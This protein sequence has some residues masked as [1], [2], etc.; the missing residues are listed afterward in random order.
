MTRRILERVYTPVPPEIVNTGEIGVL[1][2]AHFEQRYQHA[3]HYLGWTRDLA[4]RLGQHARGR[5]SHLLDVV[6]RA[7]I[8]WSVVRTWDGDRNFERQIKNSGSLVRVCPSCTD[9]PRFAKLAHGTPLLRG[10]Q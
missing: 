5:G 10:P 3:G 4:A 6:N 2:L 7:G 9:R 1:Y 8:E